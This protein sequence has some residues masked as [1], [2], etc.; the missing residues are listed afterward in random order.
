[1]ADKKRVWFGYAQYVNKKP[2]SIGNVFA[3]SELEAERLMF[4]L[5]DTVFPFDPPTSFTMIPGMVVTETE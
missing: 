2:F 5:W 3:D 4:T 1:M